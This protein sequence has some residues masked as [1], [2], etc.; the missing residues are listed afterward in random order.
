MLHG[1][2]CRVAPGTSNAKRILLLTQH[3]TRTAIVQMFINADGR[4]VDFDAMTTRLPSNPRSQTMKR[5]TPRR[6]RASL[7]F[8]RA[9]S[10]GARAAA[11][12]AL[13]VEEAKT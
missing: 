3:P 4:T 1:L 12:R 13:P 2:A 7:A 10:S 6:G 9:A 11:A 8:P 5:A